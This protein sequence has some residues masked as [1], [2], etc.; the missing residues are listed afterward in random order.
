MSMNK[1]RSYIWEYFEKINNGA[2]CNKTISTKGNTSNLHAHLKSK[3]PNQ[4]IQ[5]HQKKRH[6]IEPDYSDDDSR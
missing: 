3:H 1:Q 4:L 2:K 6:N 5:L